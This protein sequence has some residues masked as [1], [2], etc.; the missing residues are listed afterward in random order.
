[1]KV[2][3]NE[4]ANYSDYLIKVTQKEIDR[5]IMNRFLL[6]VL[7]VLIFIGLNGIEI[8]ST[9]LDELGTQQLIFLG[10]STISYYFLCGNIIAYFFARTRLNVN[11][12]GFVGI[13]FLLAI[14]GTLGFGLIIGV[15]I[16][17]PIRKG[18]IRRIKRKYPESKYND[19]LNENVSANADDNSSAAL[20]ALSAGINFEKQGNYKQ[21][22]SKY[23]EGYRLGD[24]RGAYYVARMIEVGLGCNVDITESLRWEKR[25]ADKGVALSQYYIGLE[26]ING[27][28][29]LQN[30]SLGMAYLEKAANQE[31]YDALFYLGCKFYSL[32]NKKEVNFSKAENY[33]IRAI[34][35][36]ENADELG[37]AYNQLGTMWSGVWSQTED[38]RDFKLSVQL[39]HVAKSYRNEDGQE[40]LAYANSIKPDNY[41]SLET[42]LSDS[43]V[44]E[45]ISTYKADQFKPSKE[46]DTQASTIEENN[47]ITNYS[48]ST[49]KLNAS[50][51][52]DLKE[53]RTGLIVISIIKLVCFIA[54]LIIVLY[55]YNNS[56]ELM[57][58][59]YFIIIGGIVVGGLPGL[60]KAF[61]DSYNYN[62]KWDRIFNVPK[63]K[64]TIDLDKKKVKVKKN[65]DWLTIIFVTLMNLI[66]TA[67]AAP[68]EVIRDSYRVLVINKKIK[69]VTS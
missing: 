67:C 24:G 9:N 64:A 7:I 35:A 46:S 22:K 54:G 60:P 42:L 58:L 38:M 52:Y 18:I 48:S 28:N 1:M 23:T 47:T 49:P 6:L 51:V 5:S 43:W 61:V 37:M 3:I 59:S 8:G 40:N 65:D 21:A 15:I 33:L 36:A 19:A 12:N 26:Y 63:Y 62:N 57:F 68:F 17:R 14:V 31:D 44:D 20:H 34:K 30:T 2:D 25:A 39:Y 29:L 11:R 13:I 66:K 55:G 53:L 16:K 32:D 4:S 50:Q 69:E 45:Y 27:K 41:P 56:Q 10:V